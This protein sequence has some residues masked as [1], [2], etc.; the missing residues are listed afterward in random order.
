MRIQYNGNVGIGTT[1]P[2][3]Q[4]QLSLDSAA[5]PSTNT[6]TIA[7][8]SR[9]K[10]DIR[11]F[12]D[13]L[14]VLA[15]INPIWY[16][17]N[18]KGGFSADGKDYIGVV[19][20]DIM[21]AAPYTVGTYK[22]KLNPNDPSETELYNFNSHALTFVMINAIKEQQKEIDALNLVLGPTGTISNASSTPELASG[23]G[24]AQW[25]VNGLQ[26]LGMAL[27]DGVAS[28][29]ELVA[30]KIT[31]KQVVTQQV[32]AQQMTAKQMCVTGDDNETVCVTKDQLKQLLNTTGTSMM[33]TK[34]FPPLAEV[35]PPPAAA[36][37]E[38]NGTEDTPSTLDNL[39]SET[40][41]STAETLQ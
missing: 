7:S 8:D 21:Q 37:Q 10:Q 31:S 32:T 33:T 6:W 9:I 39:G 16:R 13:G 29:K 28:L 24:I 12:S 22:A 4:L 17:Y 11:P 41:T 15:N 30:D 1:S 14:S 40:A 3:Y 20:Q 2:S 34:V 18:G 36:P 19:A 25:L 23:G 35:V 26:S 5:K 27:Q 38:N